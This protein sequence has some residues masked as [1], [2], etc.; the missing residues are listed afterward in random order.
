MEQKLDISNFIPDG[1]GTADCIIVA[2]DTMHIIDFKYGLGVFVEAKE[3]PQMMCYSLGALNHFS[4]LY[5]IKFITMH[6][7]QP[8]REN[9]Q[10][11][12]IKVEALLAW[13]ECFLKPKAL[14]AQKGEG[15]FKCGPWCQF[16]K[17]KIKCRA[18]AEEKLKLAEYDFQKPPL[19]SDDEIENVLGV[20]PDLTRW[21]RD[22]ENF[23]TEEA[24]ANG[25]K[26]NGFKVVEGRAVR[27]YKDEAAVAQRLE[28][29]GYKDIYKQNLYNITE[30]TKKL[31]KDFDN[32]LG[33]LV[34][35]PVGKPTLVP[36]DDRRPE[37]EFVK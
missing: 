32:V 6:I 13:G 15:E 17:A 34:I 23:A 33:D 10:S 27:R 4:S 8:R 22:V 5:D 11:W 19:L 26:W 12:T 35:R 25:K 18:R 30:M 28:A 14:L 7:F 37:I 20:I 1:Y 16:C 21:A 9:V 24:V 3:N 2:E 36:A 29:K 31:G